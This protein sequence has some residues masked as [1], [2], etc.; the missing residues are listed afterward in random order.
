[1][2][3]TPEERYA[4]ELRDLFMA[5]LTMSLALAP[6][7]CPERISFNDKEEGFKSVY[8]KFAEIV[9]QSQGHLP[10]GAKMDVPAALIAAMRHCISILEWQPSRNEPALG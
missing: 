3:K 10:A 2:K 7:G 9:K 4:Q 1:M 8:S 5:M 6:D